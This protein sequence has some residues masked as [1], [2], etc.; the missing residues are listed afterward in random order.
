MNNA[1]KTVPST[2]LQLRAKRYL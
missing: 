1:I 2:H